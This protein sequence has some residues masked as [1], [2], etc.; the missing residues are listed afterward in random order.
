MIRSKGFVWLATRHSIVGVWWVNTPKDEYPEGPALVVEI[1]CHLE[2]EYGDWQQDIVIIIGNG[3]DR[4]AIT[5][6]LEP[7]C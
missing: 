1:K 7:V 4:E 5:S 2:G 6:A 3:L